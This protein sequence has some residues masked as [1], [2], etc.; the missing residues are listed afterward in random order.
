MTLVLAYFL[1]PEDFGLLAMM[2]VFI[3]VAN[4]I[5]DSGM[6]Q[7]LVRKVEAT[8]ADYNTAFY[9][10]LC[11]GLVSYTVLYVVAP[12]ISE[13]YQESRL[14]ELIRVTG[15]VILLNSFQVIQLAILSRQLDFF[16]LLKS[17]LPAVLVSGSIAVIMA[18]YGFGVWALVMQMIVSSFVTTLLLWAHSSWRPTNQFD[19]V[20]F[21]EMYSFGYKIFLSGLIN[22]VF[23]NI[24]VVVI[25]K[26]FTSATAGLYFFADRL[27][28]IIIKQLV[29]AIQQVT[30]PALAS[31]QEDQERLKQG[32]RKVMVATSFLLSP[33]LLL[34][35]A[36]APPLFDLIFPA[37]WEPAVPYLQ[38]MCIA[39]V[40]HP[41]HSINLNILKVKGR[42]DLFLGLEIFKRILI[43]LILFFTYKHGV[44]AILIG[45]IV[46]SI[47]AYFPNSY[48]SRG[49]INYS[50]SE[51]MLDF[52]PSIALSVMVASVV[53][54]LSNYFDYPAIIALPGLSIVGIAIYI[55]VARAFRYRAYFIVISLF[56]SLLK[57]NKP[58]TS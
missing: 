47:I 12:G 3:A 52:L 38:L 14:V 16:R 25:A 46:H 48:Y 21:K 7:A 10:N 51:Q 13:F 50:V 43:C 30:Y 54:C 36:L 6:K 5:M 45:S 44:I 23:N 22:T 17:S 18:Y 4:S 37:R 58:L 1:L 53:Y 26:I 32:Y 39:S 57:R 28:E 27:R 8:Q 2:A 42:S 20:S 15:V 9:S 29:S 41:L 40:L 31:I 55:F 19:W 24:Y 49:L 11:F 35:A 33:T 56:L 34:L